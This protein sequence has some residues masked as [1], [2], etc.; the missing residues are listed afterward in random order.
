MIIKEIKTR[1]IQKIEMIIKG[2]INDKKYLCHCGEGFDTPQG[3]SGHKKKHKREL[4][5]E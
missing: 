4:E 3:L 2:M 1:R 5:S